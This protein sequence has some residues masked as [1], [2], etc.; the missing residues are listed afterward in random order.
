MS[1]YL[2]KKADLA[3]LVCDAQDLQ[4]TIT[5]CADNI[6]QQQAAIKQ[7]QDAMGKTQHTLT[8]NTHAQHQLRAEF[9]ALRNAVADKTNA[10]RA[11]VARSATSSRDPK[12]KLEHEAKRLLDELHPLIADGRLTRAEFREARGTFAEMVREAV[13]KRAEEVEERVLGGLVEVMDKRCKRGEGKKGGKGRKEGKMDGIRR[14]K[15]GRMKNRGRVND[16]C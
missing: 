3:L 11:C 8:Q 4:T 15:G 14:H 6:K 2:L 7:T 10:L 9:A 1:T 12:R 5:Q 13:V 16:E